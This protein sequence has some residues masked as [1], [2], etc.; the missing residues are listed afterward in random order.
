MDVTLTVAGVTR[1]FPGLVAKQ[2]AKGNDNFNISDK[3]TID[4]VRYQVGCNITRIRE[5]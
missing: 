4:G 2:S 1:E 5:K 3:V